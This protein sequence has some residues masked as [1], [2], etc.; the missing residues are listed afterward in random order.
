MSDC[1]FCDIASGKAPASFVYQDEVTLAFMDIST[2]NP[3]QVVA[4]PRQHFVYLADMDEATGSRLMRT[5]MRICRAIRTSGIRCDGVNLFLA[6][7]EAAGQEVF[8]LHFL[9]IPRV[10]G[11]SMK[12]NG[13]WMSPTRRELDD[14][15]AKIRNAFKSM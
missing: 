8:H 7:G 9:I 4:I 10:R 13:T 6:D 3:G 1:V 2:L 11:D 12:V 5:A 15:A 14:T